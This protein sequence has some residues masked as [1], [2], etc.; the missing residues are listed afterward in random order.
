MFTLVVLS[1]KML[2]FLFKFRVA[3]ALR[4]HALEVYLPTLR[5]TKCSAIGDVY[6]L[7]AEV[8]G[9]TLQRSDTWTLH[10]DGL[11]NLRA[12]HHTP[13][14]Q[15]VDFYRKG[16]IGGTTLSCRATPEMTRRNCSET[17]IHKSQLWSA[18]TLVQEDE[19][20]LPRRIMFGRLVAQ[21]SKGTDRSLKHSGGTPRKSKCPRGYSM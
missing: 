15:V 2:V 14:L 11:K 9:A 8:V 17:I 10:P 7:K 3:S 18:R 5:S 12:T 16:R 13:L 1:V 21:G 4:G 6:L 20:R 19:A